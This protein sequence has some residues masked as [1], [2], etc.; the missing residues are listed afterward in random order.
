MGAPQLRV[1][2]HLWCLAWC[3]YVKVRREGRHA[4]YSIS[5]ERVLAILRLG[6]AILQDN[7]QH[8]EACEVAGGIRDA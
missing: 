3:R 1:S 5:D 6:E 7:L 2:D 4:F 8:V